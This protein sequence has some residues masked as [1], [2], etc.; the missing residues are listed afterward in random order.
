MKKALTDRGI[1]VRDMAGWLDV[2]PQTVSAW[3]SGNREPDRRTL[4]LWAYR[5]EVPLQWL[6]TGD[7]TTTE[8]DQ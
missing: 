8:S 4:M 2:S 1:P 6:M 5:T 7:E 3:L